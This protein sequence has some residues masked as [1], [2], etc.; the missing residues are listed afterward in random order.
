MKT[1]SR[2][3][4]AS[5]ARRGGEPGPARRKRGV[6]EL[7]TGA[8][9]AAIGLALVA[10]LGRVA[11]LGFV[12]AGAT[13]AQAAQGTQPA[14]AGPAPESATWPRDVPTP[15]GTVRMFEPQ[16]ESLVGDTLVSRA[17]ISLT[18]PGGDALAV[19]G[20]ARFTAKVSTEG[21]SGSAALSQIVVTRVLLPDLGDAD[22]ARVKAALEGALAKLHPTLPTERLSAAVDSARAAARGE[23]TLGTTP[24]RILVSKRPA[25]LMLI[26]GA[27]QRRPIEGTGLEQVVNTPFAV[28]YQPSSTRYFTSN[29]RFWYAASEA[30][31]PWSAIGE[32]PPEIAKAVADARQKADEA[33]RAVGGGADESAAS[34]T[35][36]SSTSPAATAPAIV[37]STEPA[38]LLVFDG[39]PSWAPLT[40]TDLLVAMN[41]SSDVFVEISTQ[42]RFVLLAGRWFEA[43]SL[44]GPWTFVTADRLPADFAKIPPETAKAYVRASVAGTPEAEDA[45]LQTEIPQTTAI[46]RRTAK[47]DVSY[48][49]EPRFEAIPGTEVAYAVNTGAQVLRIHDRFYAVDQG[50]W[51]TAPGPDGPW[52]VADARPPEVESIP[53]S[54]PVYNTRY[55]YVYDST[56]EY[57]QVGYQPGYVGSYVYGPT[58]VYGTGYAYRPWYGSWFYAR[59]YTWGFGV[60]YVPTWGYTWFDD[61]YSDFLWVGWGWSS[62]HHHHHHHHDCAPGWYGPAGPRPVYRPPPAYRPPPQ[63]VH[64][65]GPPQPVRY[66]PAPVPRPPTAAHNLYAA[67]TNLPRVAP[68]ATKAPKPY[69]APVSTPSRPSYPASMRPS[70]A[71]T[72]PNASPAPGASPSTGPST[73][74]PGSPNPNK[75]VPPSSTPSSRP[76]AGWSNPSHTPPSVSPRSERA[77]AAPRTPSAPAPTGPHGWLPNGEQRERFAAPIE[78]EPN[79]RPSSAWAPVARPAAGWSRPE[80]RFEQRAEPRSEPRLEQRHE[81]RYEPRVASPVIDRGDAEPDP[82]YVPRTPRSSVDGS[83]SYPERQLSRQ[84]SEPQRVEREIELPR[85]AQD[86]GRSSRGGRA[87]RAAPAEEPR[88]AM[89]QM[90]MP[91]VRAPEPQRSR[92]PASQPSFERAQ[93]RSFESRAPSGFAPSTRPA[94]SFPAPTT[95]RGG[96][97]PRHH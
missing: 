41:T 89:P 17:A 28:I 7:L 19:F 83:R 79:A 30:T 33:R 63:P 34:A 94:P 46:D 5:T 39:D 27:P 61:P 48:D 20:A 67:P 50:V 58:V 47:L 2:S 59:P 51:F 55:V 92:E 53:P 95:N 40:G 12:L 32:P 25:V 77:P 11:V 72:A 82:R 71:T 87:S 78:R 6:R 91:S 22:E 69:V 45:V 3:V 15:D 29:G 35:A 64:A 49:G 65:G 74:Q 8:F 14:P 93:P 36:A 86:G 18:R 13:P 38:E 66:V 4:A 90:A 43:K 81:N 21:R 76:G 68:I 37:V 9:C 31:G 16:V 26:D 88:V 1:S 62:Y 73:R 85:V 70:P 84:P 24:P 75:Y 54:S 57:V 60:R 23:A 96:N 10:V 44:D 80:P 42:R 56:P 97:P 52:E